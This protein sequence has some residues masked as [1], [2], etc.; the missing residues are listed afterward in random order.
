MKIASTCPSAYLG[1]GRQVR[2]RSRGAP[3][4]WRSTSSQ[5]ASRYAGSRILFPLSMA[6]TKAG[7]RPF[8]GGNRCAPRQARQ[9]RQAS[10]GLRSSVISK[11]SKATARDQGSHAQPKDD[12][13]LVQHQ[14]A[15]FGSPSHVPRVLTLCL[16]P[17]T[18]KVLHQELRSTAAAPSLEYTSKYAPNEENKGH[19][20]RTLKSGSVPSA[21]IREAV[22]CRRER[23]QRQSRGRQALQ[24]LSHSGVSSCSPCTLM[25]GLRSTCVCCR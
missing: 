15:R 5:V 14:H 19:A 2:V 4:V 8:S 24:N 1:I 18:S 21:I 16:H 23:E 12:N 22:P 13:I 10:S 11:H 3:K 25:T 9:G 20:T 17:T 6:G 7:S